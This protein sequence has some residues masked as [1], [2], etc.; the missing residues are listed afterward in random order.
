MKSYEG[1]NDYSLHIPMSKMSALDTRLLH[2]LISSL[3]FLLFSLLFCHSS[4]YV[5]TKVL[6]SVVM[7]FEY[8]LVA[9]S[10]AQQYTKLNKDFYGF[11]IHVQWYTYILIWLDWAVVDFSLPKLWFCRAYIK[12]TPFETPHESLSAERTSLLLGSRQGCS[13]ISS[14]FCLWGVSVILECILTERPLTSRW[15]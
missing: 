12:Q 14:L 4:Y 1:N 8:F 2:S 3:L 15:L 13:S 5:V 11:N 7:L 10:C 6:V 9:L